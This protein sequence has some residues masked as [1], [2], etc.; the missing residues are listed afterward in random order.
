L[1]SPS[2]GHWMF[3]AGIAGALLAARRDFMRL[4]KA[5]WR[6]HGSQ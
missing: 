5:W 3:V 2:A 6:K 4:W 1:I